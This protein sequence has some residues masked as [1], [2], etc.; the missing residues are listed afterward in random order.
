MSSGFRQ[1]SYSLAF[2]C[3]KMLRVTCATRILRVETPYAFRPSFRAQIEY[4]RRYLLRL[5]GI[6]LLP[7]KPFF[8]FFASLRGS[9]EMGSL[10]GS[11]GTWDGRTRTSTDE[12]GQAGEGVWYFARPSFLAGIRGPPPCLLGL[13]CGTPADPHTRLRSRP[14]QGSPDYP[15]NVR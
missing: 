10:A 12:H 3:V 9:C 6:S 5:C 8:G 4:F 15:A 1:T 11:V 7:V 14:L 13:V 2:L